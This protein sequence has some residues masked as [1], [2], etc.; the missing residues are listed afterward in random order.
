MRGNAEEF[1]REEANRRFSQIARV[2]L[3][4]LIAV[5]T[6]EQVQNLA[7]PPGNRLEPLKGRAAGWHSIRINDHW[8]IVFRW[9]AQGPADVSITDYHCQPPITL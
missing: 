3:R 6:A 4:K 8:R 2:A 5:D 9:T 7:V 1:F